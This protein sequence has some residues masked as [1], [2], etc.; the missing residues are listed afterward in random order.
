MSSHEERV[1][2]VELYALRW[3]NAFDGMAEIR[4]ISLAD[5]RHLAERIAALP[6]VQQQDS[7]PLGNQRDVDLRRS[8]M[9]ALRE[10]VTEALEEELAVETVHACVDQVAGELTAER[11]REVMPGYDQKLKRWL[12]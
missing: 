9:Q 12:S 2:A 4:T 1:R 10:V 3:L 6:Q 11:R 8:I 5:V 7:T